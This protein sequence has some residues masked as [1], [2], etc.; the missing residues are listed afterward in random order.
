M[1]KKTFPFS[2][3]KVC[4]FFHTRFEN[5]IGNPPHKLTPT[6]TT[7]T[8]GYT[9]EV[10]TYKHNKNLIFFITQHT[11]FFLDMERSSIII[12]CV[13]LFSVIEQCERVSN[14]REVRR[15]KEI[16]FYILFRCVVCHMGGAERLPK[17]FFS[18]L[19]HDYCCVFM[20]MVLLLI[21]SKYVYLNS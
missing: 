7:T 12:L 4:D 1:Q 18:P 5:L 10:A 9:V 16:I 13:E 19:S 11:I 14:R 15:R 2:A 3:S 8:R 6:S 21:L 20:T 17:A